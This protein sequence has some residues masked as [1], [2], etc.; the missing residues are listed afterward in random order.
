MTAM[1][2][3]DTRRNPFDGIS[4]ENRAK[5]LRMAAELV[6]RQ[7]RFLGEPTPEIAKK[8]LPAPATA[9]PRP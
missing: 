7:S 2:A 9:R 8:Y 3:P 6:E 4:P 5:A 1:S